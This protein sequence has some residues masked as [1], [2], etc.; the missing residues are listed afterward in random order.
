MSDVFCNECGRTIKTGNGSTWLSSDK[1]GDFCNW[2]CK[3]A[4]FE[5]LEGAGIVTSLR[6]GEEPDVI[7]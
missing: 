3:D 1:W 6:E 2:V 5:A 7:Y 4:F